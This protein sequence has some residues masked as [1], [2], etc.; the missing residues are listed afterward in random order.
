[1][2]YRS[3]KF[4]LKNYTQ[5]AAVCWLRSSATI[6]YNGRTNLNLS[7]GHQVA[8]SFF[9]KR[10][11]KEDSK[12]P[13][14][15]PVEAK[16][17]KPIPETKPTPTKAIAP[18]TSGKIFYAFID[19]QNLFWGGRKSIGFNVDYAKLKSYIEKK[20]NVSKI[21]YYAGLR[22]F[23]FEYSILDKDPL[24]L[25]KLEVYVEEYKTK[26]EATEIEAIDR[27]LDKIKFLK[28]IEAFGYTL[29]I[30]PAK[31]HYDELDE[32]REH[33][34]LK[35]NC[36]VDMTF[37]MMRYL[38]QYQGVVAMT[39]DGDFATVLNYLKNRDRQVFI[40]SRWHRTARELKDIVGKNFVDIE[41]LRRDIQF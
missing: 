35:A 27:T 2:I 9:M 26:A 32:A 4:K 38:E 33:P 28:K 36:D 3:R 25:D 29:K 37:D 41:N 7:E 14:I 17:V 5:L 22:I 31:V 8:F 40:L 30:K 10:R 18:E 21:F 20:Y 34:I 19:A 15:K 13:I 39:G 1:M 24:D 12:K 16:A 11:P 23:D 6:D